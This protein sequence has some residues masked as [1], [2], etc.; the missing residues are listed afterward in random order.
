MSILLA[1]HIVTAAIGLLSGSGALMLRKGSTRHKQ[2]GR[3]FVISMLLMAVTAA[4]LALAAGKILDAGSSALVCYLVLTSWLT[5]QPK[6]PG[7]TYLLIGLGICTLGG[8]LWSEWA[9]ISSG[10][11]RP[12]VPAG[13]G[14]VFAAIIALALVGD[15]RLHFRDG[16][17]RAAMLGRHLWRM[18]FALFMA[19]VSFFLSRAHLFPEPVQ[20]SGVLYVLALAPLLCMLFWLVRN[21]L[22]KA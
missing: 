13:V 2:S 10:T 11:V 22:V 17:S 5:F 3:I 12:D 6:R 9:R 20:A 7:V 8:Y 19:S 21:R 1:T 14:F 4:P 15:L 16:M 18:C